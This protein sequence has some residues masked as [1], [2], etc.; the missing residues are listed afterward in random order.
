[1][2][3]RCSV[4]QVHHVGCSVMQIRCPHCHNPVE[5]VDDAELSDVVCDSC[6]S[7]FNLLGDDTLTEVAP[8]TRTIG[9]FEL[10]QRLGVGASGAVWKA[11]D[12]KL[13]RTVA[14]KIPRKNQL[15]SRET[16]QF[17]R[18]ARAAA[19][20]KHPSIV[21]VHE[22]GREDDTVYI[23]SDFVEGVD[24]S[25]WMSGQTLTVRESVELCSKIAKALHHAHEAGVIHRDLKPSN[26]MLDADGEPHI[27]DFGLAKREAGEITMTVEGAILG[28]PAYM[29][30]E[31]ARGEGHQADRRTDVYSLGV[32]LFELLTGERPF[33]GNSRML[34]HQVLNDEAPSPRKLNG[35]I[36]K[37]L[38]TICSKCLEKDPYRRFGSAIELAND[39]DR[40]LDGRPI[41]ARP[42]GSLARG[43]RWC[44]RNPLVATLTSIVS[45]A[46]IFLLI[47]LI[48]AERNKRD[49]ILQKGI[50]A[51]ERMVAEQAAE[52]AASERMKAEDEKA[53]AEAAKARAE[54]AKAREE[55]QRRA[56]EQAAADL[57]I[58][59]EKEKSHRELAERRLYVMQIATAH[60][61]WNDGNVGRAREVLSACQWN[62]RG[63]EHDYLYTTFN[64]GQS[65]FHGHGGSVSSVA[66]S[67][68]GKR[69]VSGSRDTTLK[70]WDASTGQETL[71]LK[72]HSGSVYSVAFSPDGTRIVS[73]SFDKTLKVWDAS[74]GQEILT[75][76]GHSG[77]V[78]SVAIRRRSAMPAAMARPSMTG[79]KSSICRTATQSGTRL[80]KAGW[81]S[82][83]GHGYASGAQGRD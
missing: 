56:A 39:L 28:T 65:T 63:W 35:T 31:Q 61:E 64:R 42:I 23:V 41:S 8:E 74:T 57:V 81:G 4:G 11:R 21:S 69:I 62:L 14:I 6:S 75:L 73:G 40:F 10:V 34:L 37:D 46:A 51:S 17:L 49:A 78:Y 50:A 70:V 7:S 24:L 58:A 43:W 55:V 38:E 9:H 66:F 76:K 36:P 5:V 71:T 22:V 68:D 25:D 33:R 83:A 18:E 20:L 52:I 16:E 30:P 13:D 1:M 72:G 2:V 27:M 32:I 45:V 48:I 82:A 29:S 67:P 77:I 60:R 15:S 47:A 79:W 3:F 59:Q 53:E 19:Q 12:T 80:A 26:I 54:A 44:M